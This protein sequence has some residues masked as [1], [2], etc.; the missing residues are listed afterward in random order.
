MLA[1]S[2]TGSED[3]GADLASLEMGDADVQDA[4]GEIVKLRYRIPGRHHR[5]THSTKCSGGR[6]STIA[7]CS[8]C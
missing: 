3:R 5:L 2:R 6:S 7:T 1:A 8:T 4:S